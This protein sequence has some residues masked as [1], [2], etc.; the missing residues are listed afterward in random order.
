MDKAA[1]LGHVVEHVKEQSERA[2]EASKSS[3]IPSEMDEVMIDEVESTSHKNDNIYMKASICC[4]DRPE[5]FAEMKSALKGVGATIAE[6]EITSL[7]GRMKAT[8]I[9]SC[10]EHTSLKHSL[11]MA[12]SRLVISSGST[13][14]A[15]SK[16]QRFFY[17]TPR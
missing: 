16:R 9:L 2:K 11:K 13:Y 3:T 1:L 17:P 5:F 8:F 10:K 7:G 6:A 15:R 12:L 4:D 14:S